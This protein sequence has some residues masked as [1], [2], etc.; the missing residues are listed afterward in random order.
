ME[1][2]T[3]SIYFHK[4]RTEGVQTRKKLNPEAINDYAEVI[5]AGGTLDPPVLFD[6]GKDFW[7]SAGHH[8]M[9][10]YKMA[11]QTRMPCIVKHGS[12][13]DAIAFGIKDDL[14]HKGERLS[15]AD[16]RNAVEMVLKEKPE[17]SDRAVAE[18]CGV[19]DKTVGRYR[20]NLQSTAEIPQLANRVGK[21]GRTRDVS[22]IGSIACAI[23]GGCSYFVTTDDSILKHAKNIQAIS[24]V[25]P[26][27]LVRDM[28]L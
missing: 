4:I 9:A 24:V 25:G 22:N 18:L 2:P 3:R 13:W 10:A 5:K 23:A 28:N 1:T 16:K 17:M 19:N 8:R 15:N 26:A 20:T 7:L 6:D 11:G 12:K 21:D 27:T 14:A